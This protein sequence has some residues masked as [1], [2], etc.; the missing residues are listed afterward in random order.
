MIN[1]LDTIGQ[2]DNDIFKPKKIEGKSQMA[3]KPS[4]KIRKIEKYN[5]D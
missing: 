2:K 1:K 3:K 5:I 4:E